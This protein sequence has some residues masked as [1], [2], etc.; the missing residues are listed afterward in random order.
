MTL[1]TFIVEDEPHVRDEIKYLLSRYDR[2]QIVG[3]ADS[4]L[5]AIS[6]IHTLLPDVVFLDIRLNDAIDGIALGKK[7]AEVNPA[8]KIV[9]VTAFDDRAIEG[10]ELGAVDYV[11]KPFSEERL[12]KTIER[13]LQDAPARQEPAASTLYGKTGDKIILKKNEIWKLLDIGEICYF[14]SR[15]HI[16][17]A[18]TETDI[19]TLNYTL[20]ELDEQLPPEKFLRTHKS[21][22]VN[23]GFI[24][25][26]IPWFN[27]TYKIALKNNK[28]EIPVSRS[29]MKKFK[30]TLLMY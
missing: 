15:D 17:I 27:Y 10:F 20:R 26:I 9:F 6:G 7:I 3:E 25:E 22:I 11:L 21:F 5:D 13:L 16:T 19:Y 30:S 28:E 18:V 29:Y 14:Q 24:H 1:K 4:A 12:G 2:I 8:I 23:V